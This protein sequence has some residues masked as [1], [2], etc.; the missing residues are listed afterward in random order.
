MAGQ[1]DPPRIDHDQL[2]ARKT[3][4]FQS[5]DIFL[6]R[7]TSRHRDRFVQTPEY[8]VTAVSLEPAGAAESRLK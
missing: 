3:A 1:L 7:L 5:A 6:N 2:R 4:W 8:K